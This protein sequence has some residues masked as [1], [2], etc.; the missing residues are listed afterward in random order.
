MSGVV[1]VSIPVTDQDR[2]AAFYTAHLGF[3]VVA[4]N[5]MGPT[6][7]WVQLAAGDHP[8]HLTLTTWFETMAAGTLEG[9]VIDVDDPDGC[10]AELVAAGAPCSDVEDQDWGRYFTCKD[11]DGNGLVVARTAT[12]ARKTT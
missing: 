6:M 2:A 12:A 8:T 7:R 10:R 5:P 9:L 4:D 3:R 11:P 1:M